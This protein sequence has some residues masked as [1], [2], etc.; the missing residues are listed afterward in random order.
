[1]PAIDL[2]D[3]AIGI[4]GPDEG[5]GFAV[6]LAKVAIDRGLQIRPASGRCR[7]ASARVRVAKKLSTA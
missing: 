7:A 5:F 1:M 6:V 2:F 4:G 3:D